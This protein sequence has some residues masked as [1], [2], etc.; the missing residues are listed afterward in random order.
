MSQFCTWCDKREEDICDHLLVVLKADNNRT[1]I[2]VKAVANKLPSH[3][4]QIDRYA[5]ILERLGKSAAAQYLR[6]KLPETKSSRSGDLGEILAISYIEEETPW[7]HTIRKLRWKDHREIPMRGDDFIAICFKDN[8]IQFLKGESK[9][10]MKVSKSTLKK[11]RKALSS[12]NERP[13]PHALAFFSDR[14]AEEGNDDIADRINDAQFRGGISIN[15]VS[16]MIFVFSA[17]NPKR[18]LKTDL[19]EYNGQAR[20]ISVMLQIETHQNFIKDVYDAVIA[21][22][23]A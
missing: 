8:K 18:L 16:H 20:Q 19:S 11:A 2:G 6:S 14:L 10:R 5:D 23:N 9:S 13:T 12:H 17:N 22:G 21:D 1:S 7:N 3:Y 15:R 4:M